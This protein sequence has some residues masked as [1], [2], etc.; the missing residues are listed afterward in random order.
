M[1]TIKK[2]KGALISF[3]IVVFMILSAISW[4]LNK[5][6]FWYIIYCSQQLNVLPSIV[7]LAGYQLLQHPYSSFR[8]QNPITIIL[9][10]LY[11]N[12]IISNL[13][14]TQYL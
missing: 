5:I 14:C 1:N 11:Y 3:G 6:A 10:H 2:Q 8:F 9:P 13:I 7:I 4:S 12:Y